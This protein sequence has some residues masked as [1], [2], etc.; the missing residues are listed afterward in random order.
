MDFE[1]EVAPVEAEL[2]K[3]GIVHGGRRRVRYGRA[4]HGAEAR[5][6]VNVRLTGL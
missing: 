1:C 2:F 5:G 3:G 6:S 4:V